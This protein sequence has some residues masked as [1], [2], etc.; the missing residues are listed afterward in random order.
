MKA[1]IQAWCREIA[2]KVTDAS[3]KG[4]RERFERLKK[5][6]LVLMSQALQL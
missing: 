4:D 6:Y 1:R 5:L 2:I 3:D